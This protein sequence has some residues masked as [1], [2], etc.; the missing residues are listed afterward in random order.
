ML[1]PD[2]YAAT[3]DI[4]VAAAAA[5]AAPQSP[6]SSRISPPPP[7]CTCTHRAA[8]AWQISLALAATLP[9]VCAP[10]GASD[11][12]VRSLADSPH[13]TVRCSVRAA[14]AQQLLCPACA[15]SGCLGVQK[16]TSP[17]SSRRH[18]QAHNEWVYDVNE[19]QHKIYTNVAS[20][21]S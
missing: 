10:D 12:F 19:R 6:H 5:A 3:A 8:T 2:R 14:P 13:R 15:F 20:C 21:C 7:C 4:V 17:W 11:C 9:G 18:H 16:T 1:A